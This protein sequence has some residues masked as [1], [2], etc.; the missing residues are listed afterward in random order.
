MTPSF[1]KRSFVYEAADDL[2]PRFVKELQAVIGMESKKDDAQLHGLLAQRLKG[3]GL[4]KEAAVEY[5]RASNL[6]PT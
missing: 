2:K 3:A 1:K 5:K 6:E 4:V